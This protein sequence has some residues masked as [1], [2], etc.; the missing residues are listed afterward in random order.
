MLRLVLPA[1]ASHC[2]RSGWPTAREW[3]YSAGKYE[4]AEL[5]GTVDNPVRHGRHRHRHRHGQ[6][7][8]GCRA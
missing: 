5:A 7:H 6:R 8:D 3:R 4:A 1:S 2:H